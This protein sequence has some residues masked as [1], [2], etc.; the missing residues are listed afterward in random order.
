MAS[1]TGSRLAFFANGNSSGSNINLVL[2]P[3]GSGTLATV[4]GAYNIEVFTSSVGSPSLG[5]NFDASVFIQGATTLAGGVGSP[6]PNNVLQAGSLGST[7]QLLDGSFKMVDQ[8][9]FETIKIVGNASSNDTVIGARGDTITTSAIAGSAAFVDATV[10]KET[11]NGGGGTNLVWGGDFDSITGGSGPMT[12]VGAVSGNHTHMTINGGA[13]GLSAFAFGTKNS[14]TGGGQQT[15]IDDTYGSG[16]GSTLTG[17]SGAT[18]FIAG[19]QGDVLKGGSGQITVLQAA[20]G[21]QTVI[22]GTGLSTVVLGGSNDRIYAGSGSI[23][24]IESHGSGSTITGGTNATLP[25]AGTDVYTLGTGDSIVGQAGSLTVGANPAANVTI[26]G[27]TGNLNAFSLGPNDSVVGASKGTTFINDAYGAG[28]NSTLIGGGSATTIIAGANDSIVGKAGGMEVRIRS[29]IGKAATETV[30]LS[31]AVDT[32]RDV[33]IVGGA[34]TNASVTGFN[35]SVDTIASSTSTGAQLILTSTKDGGGNVVLHF[36]D[37]STMTL[38]GVT[39][40]NL[41]TFTG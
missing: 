37:S 4:A 16:G 25:G 8:T 3:D 24:L 18:T 29:D 2:T 17:G 34:G 21:S 11:V 15:F 19:A 30:N 35:T 5:T 39:N 41:I 40:V 23:I 12:V 28:G 10:A 33:S 7:E 22:G 13:G 36:N 32:V 31:A 38:A 26:Q 6:L 14:I 27:G 20:L 1:V 9:G